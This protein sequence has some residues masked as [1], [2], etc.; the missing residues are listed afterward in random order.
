M[1]S[2][3]TFKSTYLVAGGPVPTGQRLQLAG[4]VTAID[5]Q[6]ANGAS[7][8]NAAAAVVNTKRAT[9]VA[10]RAQAASSP[11][12]SALVTDFLAINAA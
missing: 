5:L 11:F 6:V 1:G 3:A 2:L 4:P 10:H 12:Q 7:V 8:T 9:R